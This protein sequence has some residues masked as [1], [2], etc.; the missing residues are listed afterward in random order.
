MAVSLSELHAF[1]ARNVELL[2]RLRME[3]ADDDEAALAVAEALDEN[4]RSLAEAV[5]RAA[6]DDEP[7]GVA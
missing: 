2:D 4:H 5:A 3:L 1:L 7:P 6:G